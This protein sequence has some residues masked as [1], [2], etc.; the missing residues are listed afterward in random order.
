MTFVKAGVNHEKNTSSSVYLISLEKH[1]RFNFSLRITNLLWLRSTTEL[2]I[3][4]TICMNYALRLQYV[5]YRAYYRVQ[6]KCLQ[7]W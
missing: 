4:T 6:L 1:Q 7:P 5:Y 3:E 2:C